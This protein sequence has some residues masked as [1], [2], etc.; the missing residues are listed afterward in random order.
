MG[1]HQGGNRNFQGGR[2]GR[3][4]YPNQRMNQGMM[5]QNFQNMPPAAQ[6]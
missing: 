4:Q 6:Q 1:G 3:Q 5:Q 2:G